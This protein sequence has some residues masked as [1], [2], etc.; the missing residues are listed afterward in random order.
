M[1]RAWRAAGAGT[2]G[3]PWVPPVLSFSSQVS[4]PCGSRTRLCGLRGRCP[5]AI[6]ER[7]ELFGELTDQCVGQESNLHCPAG[8]WV[9]A[10]WARQCPA[11]AVFLS[12]GMARVGVEP[13][14]HEGLSFAALPVC[15]P[16]PFSDFSSVFDG[17]RTH[18]LHRDRVA[19]T[20]NSPT[21]T[22]VAGLCLRQAD[23]ASAGLCLRS[24]RLV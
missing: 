6:D 23:E 24:P 22:G 8:G 7:A 21:K 13:T 12:F 4:D 20:A 3:E 2:H 10:T 17:I 14:H 16:C 15:V 5:N 9:T 18:D 19:G 1:S 11:D